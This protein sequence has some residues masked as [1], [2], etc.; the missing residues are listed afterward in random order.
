MS[1][2]SQPSSRVLQDALSQAGKALV[3]EHM[4]WRPVL[5]FDFDGT[6]API[7]TDPDRAALPASTME[8]LERLAARIPCVVV[9]GRARSDVLSRLGG[10]PIAE[11]VGNHGSEPWLDTET[12]REPIRQWLPVFHQH[13]GHLPGVFIEDKGCSL[14]I[15][16]RHA[17]DGAQAVA[18]THD[19]A[20]QL[21][22]D[23]IIPGKCVLNLL[24]AGAMHKG[25]GLCR[26]METLQK[27]R[28]LYVGDDDTDEDVFRLA[29]RPTVLGIRIEY[30]EHTLADLFLDG[31]PEIDKLLDLLCQC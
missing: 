27:T 2:I 4:Q 31:Q 22:V 3:R 8:R 23:R 28:A 7:V 24:P 18:T 17:K 25:A 14:S 26:A 9:S 12:L 5:A 1:M 21:G 11:V 16:Y 6:L 30:S 20:R 13:L 10:L 15:H 19:V 29:P